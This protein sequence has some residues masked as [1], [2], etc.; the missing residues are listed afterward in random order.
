MKKL[1]KEKL[2]WRK[3]SQIKGYIGICSERMKGRGQS[4]FMGFRKLKGKLTK[5]KDKGRKMRSKASLKAIGEDDM[6]QL[7]YFRRIGGFARTRTRPVKITFKAES[8]CN[9]ILQEKA[10]LKDMLAYQKIYLDHDR[11]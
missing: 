10:R 1:K 2:Q 3:L 7:E 6:T 9:R 11:T 8:T 5:Q 4:L